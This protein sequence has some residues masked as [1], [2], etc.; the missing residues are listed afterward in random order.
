MEI[1]TDKY[2]VKKCVCFNVSFYEMKMIMKEKGITTLSELKE[3]K[4]LAD[5][6]KLC[7]PYIEKMIETG[8]TEF[9]I[10]NYN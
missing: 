7:V 9:E 4:Q 6:C 10:L 3:V 5:N 2:P 1:Q 8:K